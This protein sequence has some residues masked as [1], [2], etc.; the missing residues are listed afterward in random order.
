MSLSEPPE[1]G[2]V[3]APEAIWDPEIGTYVVF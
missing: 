2:M 3:F 1:A